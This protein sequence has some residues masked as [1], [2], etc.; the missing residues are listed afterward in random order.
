VANNRVKG[1]ARV[2][3][4]PP[5]EL[6]HRFAAAAAVAGLSVNQW[7]LSILARR[8]GARYVPPKVGRPPKESPA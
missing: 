3:L 1:A 8:V 6:A 5:P 7:A 2:E 4:T